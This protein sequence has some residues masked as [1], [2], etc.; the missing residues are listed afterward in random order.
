MSNLELFNC[1]MTSLTTLMHIVCMCECI[2]TVI[3]K[4][5]DQ[6]QMVPKIDRQ[7]LLLHHRM[8]TILQ[9]LLL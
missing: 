6:I 2:V 3:V 8:K 9:P 5:L 7:W 4:A 1:L